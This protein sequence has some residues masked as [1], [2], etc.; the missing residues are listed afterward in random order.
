MFRQQLRRS[1]VPARSG[2]CG[3]LIPMVAHLSEIRHSVECLGAGPGI[4]SEAGRTYGP[5]EL[6]AMVEV[7]AATLMLPVFLRHL[8]FV[9]VG[10][11]DL[12]QYTLAI[13]RADESV[14]HPY[15]PVA[16]HRAPPRGTDHRRGRHVGKGVAVCGEMAGDPG[17]PSLLLGMGLRSFSMHPS[18]IVRRQAAGARCRRRA[19]VHVAGAG[20]GCRRTGARIRA[21]SR[22]DHPRRPA[23]PPPP[24]LRYNF[25]PVLARGGVGSGSPAHRTPSAI[26]PEA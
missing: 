22:R 5:V 2:R 26:D 23:L 17:S 6:G 25:A 18:Q 13:D 12:I 9:S 19:V 15:N 21:H 8:D 3:I 14:A 20:A 7:P 4:S 10:T 11:N 16:P 24:L 1:C